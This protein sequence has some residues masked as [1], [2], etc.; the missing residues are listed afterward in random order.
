ALVRRLHRPDVN[1]VTIEDPVEIQLP[2][3]NQVQV[4]DRIGMTFARALRTVLRQDPDVVMVGEIRDGETAEIAFQ[5]A[6]TGHLVLSTIHTNDAP[7]AITR[8][9]D[10]GVEPYLIASS[11]SLVIAQR[12]VRKVCASCARPADV[13]PRL[14]TSLGIPKAEAHRLVRV[15][16]CGDCR[17]GGF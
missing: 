1:I 6:L 2:G 15:D 5:A 9:V 12:L 3:I 13:S 16:G 7:S 8:L 4:D 11:L 17:Y 10:M 14:L